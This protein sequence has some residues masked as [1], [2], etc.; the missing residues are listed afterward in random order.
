MC[1][2]CYEDYGSPKSDNNLVREL[3]AAITEVYRFH[4]TGGALH[5]VLDDWNLER[6]HI[7]FCRGCIDEF[8]AE[9]AET[10]SLSNCFALLEKASQEEAASALAIS[11]GY[12]KPAIDKYLEDDAFCRLCGQGFRE[13]FRI[14][15]SGDGFWRIKC[16][17]CGHEFTIRQEQLQ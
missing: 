12:W 1:K 11:R 8:E 13:N 15:Q 7:E 2:G 5:I 4:S 6:E 9:G 16:L 17:R 10:D 14:L 3:A